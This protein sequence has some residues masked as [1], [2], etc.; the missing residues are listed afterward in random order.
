MKGMGIKVH[1]L[2]EM[3]MFIERYPE[4]FDN[5]PFML[6][7]HASCADFTNFDLSFIRNGITGVGDAVFGRGV[8]IG[9]EKVARGYGDQSLKWKAARSKK[10]T[11]TIDTRF[12][13]IEL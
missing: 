6:G 12:G 1:T 7:Y 9:S 11:R 8:Y 13:Q 2:R 5:V 4:L 3:E 10:I